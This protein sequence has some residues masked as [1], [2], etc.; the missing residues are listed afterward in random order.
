M[1]RFYPYNIDMKNTKAFF[2]IIL[3]SFIIATGFA[4]AE[5]AYEQLEKGFGD[6]AA[7]VSPVNKTILDTSGAAPV[8]AASAPAA[9]T[10]APAAAP[11]VAPT[12]PAPTPAPAKPGLGETIKNFWVDNARNILLGGIG[13]YLGFALFGPVGLVLG[14]IAFL[15][16]GMV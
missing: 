11:A 2:L 15:A 7:N 8:P 12:P 13:A 6:R 4:F 10:P 14:A 5:T 16:L 1:E 9:T 3:G